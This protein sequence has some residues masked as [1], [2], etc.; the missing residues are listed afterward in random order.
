[1]PI[2]EGVEDGVGGSANQGLTV[3]D[4]AQM[5]LK[6]TLRGKLTELT[7]KRKA[8]LEEPDQWWNRNTRQREVRRLSVEID[9]LLD[10]WPKDQR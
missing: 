6:H 10:E 2:S 5:F 1:M 7:K 9:K 8:L 4:M 3:T